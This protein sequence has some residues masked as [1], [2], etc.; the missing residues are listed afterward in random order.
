VSTPRTEVYVICARKVRRTGM[1][2]GSRAQV[3]FFADV[4]AGNVIK[5]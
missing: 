2:A 5:K 3:D 1:A 4:N